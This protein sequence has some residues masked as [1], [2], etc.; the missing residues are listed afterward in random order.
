MFK[1]HLMFKAK[2]ACVPFFTNLLR[3]FYVAMATSVHY[4]KYFKLQMT[5]FHLT[6]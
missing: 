5:S 2:K 4:P 3:I 6:N 1:E